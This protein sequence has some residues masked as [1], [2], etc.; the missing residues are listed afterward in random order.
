MTNSQPGSASTRQKRGSDS[1]SSSPAPKVR[2]T[3]R[4]SLQ[5]PYRTLAPA[6]THRVP[7]APPVSTDTQEANTNADPILGNRTHS[8]QSSKISYSSGYVDESP[9]NSSVDTLT[10]QREALEGRL[11]A[12]KNPWKIL[13]EGGQYKVGK[14][15]GKGSFGVVY[16]GIT[17][18]GTELAIKFVS[19][20]VLSM[21]AMLIY[22]RNHERPNSHCCEMSTGRISFYLEIVRCPR[23][24][25]STSLLTT[26]QLDSQRSISSSKSVSIIALGCSFWVLPWRSCSISV[27]EVLP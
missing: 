6:Q 9:A 13:P 1:L 21:R 11:E 19:Y 23:F 15:I 26:E 5:T 16:D 24:L 7:Q 25:K 10:E 20:L 27:E 2:R 4:V 12:A 22:R 17:S 14:L 3:C 18:D 8:I